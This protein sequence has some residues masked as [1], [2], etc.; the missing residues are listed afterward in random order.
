MECLIE[1]VTENEQVDLF[2][3]SVFDVGLPGTLMT[4]FFP[5]SFRSSHFLVFT[6][7]LM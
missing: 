6:I 4:S 2:D 7:R 5:P 1:M 3:S